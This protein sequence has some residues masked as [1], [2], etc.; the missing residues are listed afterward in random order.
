MRILREYKSDIHK[1]LREGLEWMFENN[2][3]PKL[4][5]RLGIADNFM[6]NI[7]NNP[8]AGLANSTSLVYW[9]TY[10]ILKALM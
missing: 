2:L 3:Q 5:G 7:C 6:Q 8:N 10:V 9:E 4:Q 1:K